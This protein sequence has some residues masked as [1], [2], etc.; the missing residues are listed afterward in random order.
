MKYIDE[1]FKIGLLI[2]GVAL[3]AAYGISTQNGRYQL[4]RETP[5]M[6]ILDTHKGIIHSISKGTITHTDFKDNKVTA[7]TPL[8]DEDGSINID[9]EAIKKEPKGK[10][11]GKDG[12]KQSAAQ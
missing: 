11:K 3:V 12:K 9:Q 4:V 8:K 5:N 6:A 1:I 7:F 2:I 10:Q